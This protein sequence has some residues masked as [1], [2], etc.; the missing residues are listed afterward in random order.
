MSR[1]SFY[2]MVAR[3]KLDA[4][5]DWQA[6]NFKVIGVDTLLEGAV[7]KIRTRGPRKGQPTWRGMKL[8]QVVV[9]Q[10]ELDAERKLYEKTTGNCSECTGSGEVVWSVSSTE[11][12][13]YRPCPKC[14]AT[15][16]VST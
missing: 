12:T 8:Q 11:G 4:P 1:I 13:K 14:A 7:P 16:K 6:C 10:A 15:G 9:T 3:K 2:E 5:P